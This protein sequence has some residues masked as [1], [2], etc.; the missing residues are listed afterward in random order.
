MG[1]VNFVG[2]WDWFNFTLQTRHIH[3]TS[4]SSQTFF[5]YFVWWCSLRVNRINCLFIWMWWVPCVFA[6]GMCACTHVCI[7]VCVHVC[8]WFVYALELLHVYSSQYTCKQCHISIN[9]CPLKI[10]HYKVLNQ[11][12]ANFPSKIHLFS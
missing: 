5:V 1:R 8:V 2:A 12:R 3:K 9:A 7:Y 4:T 11:H 10:K 6:F